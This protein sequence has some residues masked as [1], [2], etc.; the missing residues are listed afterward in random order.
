MAAGPSNRLAMNSKLPRYDIVL[1]GA[2]HTNAHVLRM[3]RM[4]AL[5]D[6][7]L[8]CISDFPIAT[9]SGM[10]PGTL[11]GLYSP[12]RMQIDLVRLCAA[13]GARL[14]RAEV[15]GLD[16]PHRQVLLRDR[17]PVPFD[18]L[19]VG[20]G[21][22]PQLPPSG[23]ADP[24]LLTIKPM[25]TF[26]ERLDCRLAAIKQ[27]AIN[28]PWR[29]AVV[30]AG[31][32]GVEIAFCLPSH[33]KR[34]DPG[35][36]YELALIDAGPEILSGTD[37]GL[38]RLARR[39]LD[40]R[41][42]ELL[43]GH[44]VRD[45]RD[46]Q[47]M[48]ADGGAR[49]FDLA[50]WATGAVAPPLLGR[51]GLPTDEKG[52]LL[53]RP[54]LQTVADAPVFVV[55]DS[56]TSLQRPTP[57]AGVFAVRQGPVLWENLK[58]TLRREPPIEYA[59][60][61]GFLRLLASGDSRAILAYKGLSFHAAWCWKLKNYIDSRFMAKYQDYSL[62]MMADEGDR[63]P[64]SPM[65]CAGCGGKLAGAVLTRALER[66][67]IPR[68]RQVLVGLDRAD[69]AA[70]VELG[71]GAVATTVDFFAPFADDPHL[72]GRVAA[73]NAASDLF[74]V[75]SRPAAALAMLAVQAGPETQQERYVYEL[76]AGAQREFEQMG[77][78]LVGGH[79]IESPRPIV[80]FSLIAA[81]DDSP[82]LKGGLQVDDHLVLTKPLGS[83]ILLAAHMRAECRAEWYVTLER[84]L[85]A[86]N[87]HAAR[88][89]H[90]L[91]L[92]GITDITGFGLAGHLFEM[93]RAS[94]V[95]AEIWLSELPLLPGARQLL[96]AGVEST[97]A[98][99][100]RHVEARIDV[101]RETRAMAEYPIL[102]DPQTSGGLLMGVA[103]GDSD[104]LLQMLGQG[105][106]G[107]HVVGR[108]TAKSDQPRLR[109]LARRP[110]LGE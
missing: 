101:D 64:A 100:N 87:E 15:T 25:Q 60:Q 81:A 50:I 88:C 45:A 80:G 110:R 38:I 9:Y 58:R 99:A 105:A 20:I 18:V 36:R 93:L 7:R 91:R 55:G 29:I 11:A 30:G 49:P 4:D 103:R 108:V 73:L 40:A 95:S 43:L 21:S 35:C 19:S 86:S 61:R 70:I 53:T 17:P 72:V 59:A 54:T 47:L 44:A 46:G 74:A 66:L 106:S 82:T 24:M 62:R 96:A 5:R 79:T 16:L 65:Q 71:G 63:E 52:F 10:L 102:F 42:V 27:A 6:A 104:R 78:T 33:L 68:T 1:I 92:A 32:G 23:E 48:L 41:G 2:G 98:P 34:F 90:D 83:G 84:V 13:S 26:L 28:R 56:G 37:R 57:K 3:W 67:A 76:L 85:L 94:G 51:L 8:T 12:E 75:G 89:A 107:A 39:E 77:A 31:A 69:D 22:V 109:V 14:I 97:L